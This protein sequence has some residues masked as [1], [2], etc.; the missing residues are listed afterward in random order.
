MEQ[1]ANFL[2][3]LEGVLLSGMVASGFYALATI[4]IFRTHEGAKGEKNEN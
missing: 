4:Q 2:I 3:N 1:I